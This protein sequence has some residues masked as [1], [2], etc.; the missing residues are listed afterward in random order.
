[1][2]YIIAEA[3]INHNG[4]LDIAKRMVESAG[5]NGADC[6]KFQYIIAEEIADPSSPF[7][8]LFQ[9]VEFDSAQF[10]ELMAAA[11]S[12]GIDF[13]MTVPSVK[14]MRLT[15][16]LGIDKIKI[17]S[18]N[19]TN[20]ILLREVAK[21]KTGRIIHLST[22][23]GTCG[24][25]ESALADLDYQAGDDIRLFHCTAN[26]PVE[27]D[28]MNLRAIATM[29][30]AFPA[31]PV[32]YSD[33]SEG[34]EAAVA[35]LA[36]GARFFEKHF[37]LDKTMEGPDHGFSTDPARFADYVRA[38]RR[39]ESALGSPEK[40][41]AASEQTMLRNARRFLIA[42][43]SIAAGAPLTADLFDTKRV[44]DA[45]LPIPVKDIAII[46]KLTAPRAYQPGEV[47]EWTDFG[48]N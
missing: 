27:P 38:I 11:E 39:A 19:L 28:N 8:S 13:M 47:I 30:T 35:A 17:G 15:A 48:Q 4:K 1:M 18:S 26:Y 34:N 3:E 45:K 25:I 44:G 2:A 24:D 37:T 31:L 5:E 21:H 36:L 43:Q 23:M 46:E 32:G 6:V 10:A 7:Y 9:K 41:P 14:T 42:N 40:K 29:K 16:E 12:A 33:H 22:G 20:T